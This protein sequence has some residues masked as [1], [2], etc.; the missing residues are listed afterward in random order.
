MKISILL[1]IVGL[2][3]KKGLAVKEKKKEQTKA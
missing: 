3:S 2:L 1:R